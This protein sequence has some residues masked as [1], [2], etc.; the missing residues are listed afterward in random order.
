MRGVCAR[1]C[2]ACTLIE[3]TDLRLLLST[4]AA[5]AVITRGV[6][7]YFTSDSHCPARSSS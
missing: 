2:V 6:V 1:V 4:A 7:V 3:Y 5:V